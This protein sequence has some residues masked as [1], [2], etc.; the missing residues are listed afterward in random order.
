MTRPGSPR[1]PALAIFFAAIL[2][3]LPARGGA[4]GD[5]G[6]EAQIL[7]LSFRGQHRAYPLEIFLTPRVVNDNIRQQEVVI[8]HDPTR[9]VSS[10]FF[11]MVMGEA[12]EFSGSV[13]GTVADDLTTITRWDLGSGK[14]VEGNLTGME[15]IPLAVVTTSLEEWLSRHPDSEIYRPDPP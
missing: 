12:I 2:S 5:P 14:A 13:D 6:G 10:A 11:R 9:N 3:A 7:G 15:L 8:F 1:R 4:P